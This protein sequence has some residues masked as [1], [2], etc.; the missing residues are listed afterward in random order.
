MMLRN[1]LENPRNSLRVEL[2]REEEEWW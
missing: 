1:N 2:S